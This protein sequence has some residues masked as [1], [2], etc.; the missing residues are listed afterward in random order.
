MPAVAVSE[1]DSRGAFAVSF[2]ATC[3]R[4]DAVEDQYMFEHLRLSEERQGRYREY[5]RALIAL[6][7]DEPVAEIV[8]LHAIDVCA[9]RIGRVAGIKSAAVSQIILRTRSRLGVEGKGMLVYLLSS[10]L[11]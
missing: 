11:C 6:G 1:V 3:T 9:K 2:L 4:E 5:R 7:F 8:A 10:T